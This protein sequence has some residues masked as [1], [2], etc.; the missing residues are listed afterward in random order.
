MGRP[1]GRPFGQPIGR[2]FGRPIG[3]PFWPADRPAFP[4]GVSIPGSI[5]SEA[6]LLFESVVVAA[7]FSELR[8]GAGSGGTSFRLGARLAL[9]RER[10]FLTLGLTS[11]FIIDI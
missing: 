2:P 8:E 11:F 3:R 4:P 9:K 6:P 7:T 5:Y 1:I 10:P